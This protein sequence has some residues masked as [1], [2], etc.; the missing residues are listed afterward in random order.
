[1]T[2][3]EERTIHAIQ[4]IP[5]RIEE[6]T[7]QLKRIADALEK[8]S[9]DYIKIDWS[10]FKGANMDGAKIKFKNVVYDPVEG[11]IVTVEEEA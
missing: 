3:G 1:M 6:A 9:G 2:I 10:Q 4:V 5:G 7:K 8:M 11:K